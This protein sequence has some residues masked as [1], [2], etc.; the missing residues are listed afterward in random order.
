MSSAES[1]ALDRRDLICTSLLPQRQFAT[2]TTQR[3]CCS[4]QVKEDVAATSLAG[5]GRRTGAVLAIGAGA[6][7]TAGL[8]RRTLPSALALRIRWALAP[9]THDQQCIRTPPLAHVL[10]TQQQ[11]VRRA[12]PPALALRSLQEVGLSRTG[13]AGATDAECTGAMHPATGGGAA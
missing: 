11:P 1:T 2:V 8:A 7:N 3:L 10:R 12:L 13:F 5:S 9:H 4:Q 6:T